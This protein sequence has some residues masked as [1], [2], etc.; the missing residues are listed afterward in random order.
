MENEEDMTPAARVAASAAILDQILS[1][2]AT[3]QCLIA[4]ARASRY[5][6]SGDR[7]AVRDLVFDARRR[8]RSLA[9]IGGAE[10]GRGL[11]LG[12]IRA[13][14][15]DPAAVFTGDRHALARLAADE[16]LDQPPIETAPDPV[17]HDCQDWV[18]PLLV[19]ALGET[20][21]DVLTVFQ[22]RAP[23]FLRVNAARTSVD[24]AI[25]LLA[26]D[27][28]SAE[29]ERL[30]PTALVVTGNSRRV[31]SSIAYRSG[32]VELQDAASQ[33][34]VDLILRHAMGASV[35]D[36]CAGGGGK[37]LQLAAGGAARVV[38]HDADPGR[39]RDIPARAER[40]ECR[41]EL[42]EHPE[43]EFG[44]VLT[45]VPCSG[46]GAWRRQPDA[47]WTLTPERLAKLN[48][49]Q[50]QVMDRAV[51]HVKADG[52]LAYVTCSLLDSE[53]GERVASFLERHRDWRCS[54]QRR[55]SPLEGGDGFFVAIL[56]RY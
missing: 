33:A 41:I 10:S 30:S 22:A 50:D 53:N 2:G 34:V 55:F 13:A 51:R 32:V 6:G 44:C 47:K 27:G 31:Q 56:R 25:R 11:M 23:V 14:G 1:G 26:S 36:Y 48:A 17:R 19:D 45:D 24:A 7:A 29:A 21:R 18:W 54:E 46:S 16:A 28:I 52:V 49:L 20:T 8:Q 15:D 35:L 42:S 4:W 3:E 9:W 39:M 37:S 40:A 43:G 38:A 5:A 12:R